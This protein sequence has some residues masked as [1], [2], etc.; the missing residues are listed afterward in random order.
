MSL[1][2]WGFFAV[3][4][5]LVAGLESIRLRRLDEQQ[6][7]IQLHRN[8][9]PFVTYGVVMLVFLG[10]A[11]LTR[12]PLVISLPAVFCALT[13]QSRMRREGERTL[14]L[15]EDLPIPEG[16]KAV[17]KRMVLVR[18]Y[19]LLDPRK[20]N[21]PGD[22]RSPVMRVYGE[23][24]LYPDGSELSLEQE[25]REFWL[26]PNEARQFQAKPMFWNRIYAYSV[27]NED[28]N[29]KKRRLQVVG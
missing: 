19:R 7:R 24:E 23:G 2:G 28:G 6:R 25:L 5:G 18:T 1:T 16:Y 10:V 20:I 15:S 26:Q 27:R 14:R 21:Q 22:G 3:A 4:I 8:T 12:V 17:S 29:P 13:A 11:T 9:L